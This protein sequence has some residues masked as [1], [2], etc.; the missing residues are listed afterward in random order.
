MAVSN[1]LAGP[2]PHTSPGSLSFWLDPGVDHGE[3]SSAGKLSDQS[4]K[5]YVLAI[6]LPDID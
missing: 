2:S 3:G 6:L 1:A 4:G 5:P